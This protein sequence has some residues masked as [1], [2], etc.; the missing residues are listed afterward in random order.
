MTTAIY[1]HPIMFEH[2]AREGH[3][4]RPDRLRSVC[5]A[6]KDAQGLPLSFRTAEEADWDAI[7]A[8]HDRAYTQALRDAAPESRVVALDPDTSM[9][10]ASLEAARRAAGGVIQAVDAVEAGDVANAFCASRPPG[11]HATP[12]RAMGFC[13]INSVAVG[14]MHARAKHGRHRVAV[15]DFDVHHGNGTQ[16][17]F[18]S[19]A[20]AFYA[21]THEFPHYPGSGAGE[22]TGAHGNIVNAP[23]AAGAGGDAFRAAMERVVLPALDAFEPEFLFI[24]AGFDAHERDPLASLCFTAEDFAWATRALCE[25]ADQRCEGRVVSVLEGG[26]DLVALRESTLA[27]VGALAA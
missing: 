7:E 26:Y 5:D 9:G 23:L 15:V 27:H 16:D 1:T 2:P 21:S 22:E 12:S 20:D 3:P 24:S 4:E 13:L 8:V 19:D 6:L 11:H 10:P 25:V 17:A 18:W 14:A